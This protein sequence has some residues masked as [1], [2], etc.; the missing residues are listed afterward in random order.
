MCIASGKARIVFAI[1][2]ALH[3]PPTFDKL[4]AFAEERLVVSPALVIEEMD[5]REIYNLIFLPGVF[6]HELSHFLMAK[7]LGVKT[8]SF[9]IIPQ[10]LPDGRLQ[11]GYVETG[12]T[13]IVRDS[14]IGIA[15]LVTGSLFIA[16]AG[17]NRDWTSLALVHFL[18]YFGMSLLL[19]GPYWL[20]RPA[21][22]PLNGMNGF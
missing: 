5:R 17:M 18:V 6:L 15:P 20:L 14:L 9:S 7:L 3:A 21:A 4:Q 1:N 13:D 2:D 16:Y 11:M 10:S 12:Q 22:R 8:G 19:L